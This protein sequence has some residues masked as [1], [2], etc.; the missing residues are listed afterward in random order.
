[1]IA[2]SPIEG[3]VWH[4][5]FL[6]KMTVYLGCYLHW[7]ARDSLIHIAVGLVWGEFFSSS[8]L[9]SQ[10]G[11]E[12]NCLSCVSASSI[13]GVGG[14]GFD[15]NYHETLAWLQ[16]GVKIGV[17]GQQISTWSL[18]LL[19]LTLLQPPI[20]QLHKTPLCSGPWERCLGFGCIHFLLL[21]FHIITKLEA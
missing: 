13:T 20:Q 4:S 11:C 6:L 19:S 12:Y 15:S 9:V 7:A 18:P 2:H 8:N 17:S 3:L 10:S 16:A 21:L 14:G 1:M 5:G